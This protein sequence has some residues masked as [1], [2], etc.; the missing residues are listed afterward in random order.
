MSNTLKSLKSFGGTQGGSSGTSMAKSLKNKRRSGGGSNPPLH[1]V[2]A[3]GEKPLNGYG[4]MIDFAA[5][6]KVGAVLI[7]DDQVYELR[8]VRPHVRNDGQ[9]TTL[10]AW[11][12]SCPKCGTGFEVVTGLTSTGVTRRCASCRKTGKP[13][14]GKRGRKVKVGVIAA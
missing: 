14:K 3:A 11:E 13:V 4:R 12:T 7:L 1:G 2:F 6:P 10:L 5:A 9:P 8:E